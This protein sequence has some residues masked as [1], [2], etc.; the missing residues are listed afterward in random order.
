MQINLTHPGTFVT[1]GRV[2][3]LNPSGGWTDA[4]D[5]FWP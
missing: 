5:T 4:D 3:R 2:R 1:L